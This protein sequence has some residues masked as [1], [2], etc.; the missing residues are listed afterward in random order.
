MIIMVPRNSAID[1]PR[2]RTETSKG[3]TASYYYLLLLYYLLT[4]QLYIYV[5]VI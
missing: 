2:E 3:K 1:T 5:Q 4:L